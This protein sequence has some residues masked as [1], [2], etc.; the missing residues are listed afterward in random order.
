MKSSTREDTEERAA[1]GVSAANT[2][3]RMDFRGRTEPL[4]RSMNDGTH[5]YV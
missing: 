2:V 1:D 4:L 3:D 5:R